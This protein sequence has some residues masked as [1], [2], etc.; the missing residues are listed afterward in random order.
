M[1]DN[2]TDD[3]LLLSPAQ[4]FVRVKVK[5]SG[6]VFFI[7]VRKDTGKALSGM[8]A[9]KDGDTYETRNPGKEATYSR[10]YVVLSY[11][12]I[13][14]IQEFRMHKRYGT[15]VKYKPQAGPSL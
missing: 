7:H 14:D 11:D 13:A 10:H 3:D 2:Y 1:I 5:D 8:R 4:R 15:L 9:T 12:D 6:E